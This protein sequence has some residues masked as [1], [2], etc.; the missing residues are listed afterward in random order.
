MVTF[1]GRDGMGR[2]VYDGDYNNFAPRIGFAWQLFGTRTII[3]SGYGVFFGPPIPGSNTASAGFETSGNFSTPDNGITP[4][5]LLR[6]GF[7]STSRAQI[8]PEFGAVPVG[9]P[10]RFAPQFIETSRP[11]GYSQQWNLAIQQDLGWQTLLELGYLGSVGHKLPGPNTNINQ[12]PEALMGVVNAQVRRPF[13]Q[14]GN[15]TL[16][17]PM[18]GNSSYHALNVKVEKRFSH[19][20]NFLANYTFSKFID[21]VAAGFEVGVVS[22]GIQNLYN[23]RAEKSLSGNDVRNRLVWSSVYELPIGKGR[24]WL[25]QGAQSM[26]LGGW[27]LGTILLLQAGSP[28]GLVT[29]TNST[30]AFTPGSQWVN[31]L[32]N[33]ELPESERSL[34]RW[35][36]T[37]A[38]AAPA[39]FTFGNSGRALLTGP[40]IAGLD[41]SLLKNHRWKEHFN[42][43]FRFEAFN[44]LNHA[45][46]QEPGRALGSPLFGV[47]DDT[48]PARILQFGLKMEF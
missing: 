19:G 37:S 1:A 22:G 2:N 26:V 23:R 39:Q 43:Q 30:N 28:Y 9:Q 21:D 29:Q 7:P 31:V 36:D 10:V 45:N 8:G 33:P 47:I 24:R 38:V 34:D 35:F 27:N 16:L 41:V 3:R 32:R 15:V 5:F 12:V 18:W 20:L 17:T 46:F 25:S 42:I 40:G 6:D 48:L 4:P 11:L 14:F 44:I 13:P